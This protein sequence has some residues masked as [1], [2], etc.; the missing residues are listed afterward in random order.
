[1]YMADTAG[2]IS[3]VVYGPDERTRI[4]PTTRNALFTAYAPP[5]MDPAAVHAHLEDLRDNVLL[6]VPDAEVEQLETY[7][8]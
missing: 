1:M 7:R 6:V 3:V 2:I 8:A 5:G 4:T